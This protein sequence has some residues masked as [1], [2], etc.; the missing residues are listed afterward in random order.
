MKNIFFVFCFISFSN[1]LFGA[2]L[3]FSTFLGAWGTI[4]GYDIV[5]NDSGEVLVTGE[6]QASG[7]P[8]TSGTYTA[9]FSGK[10][11]FVSKFSKDGSN[12]LFSSSIGSQGNDFGYG[13]KL[14]K[15]EDIFIIGRTWSSSFP[16]VNFYDSSYNGYSDNFVCKLSSDGATIVY[17]SYIGG[18]WYDYAYDLAIDNNEN[19]FLLGSVESS[20]Y[21]KVNAFDNSFGGSVEMTLT[22]FDSVGNGII[23]STFIGGNS[24]EYGHC[25]TL[26]SFGNPILTGF[27]HSSDY[28]TI[29][30]SFD[31]SKSG[32]N[33]IIVSKFAADGQTLLFSTFIGGAG[34]DI[35][36]ALVTNLNDDVF[37]TGYSL[38]TNFPTANGFSQILNGS[39]DAIICKVS[40]DGSALLYSSFFGG[41][42]DE[43]GYG[44]SLGENS[45]VFISGNTI[46]NDLPVLN[47][48][49]STYSGGNDIFISH[50]NVLN[51]S[52]N[53]STYLG[54][55]LEDSQDIYGNP[56]TYNNG[57]V[58][59]IGYTNSNFPSTINSYDNSFGGDWDA[60]IGSLKP[61]Y[62]ISDLQIET[63][64]NNIKLTWGK[65]PIAVNYKI[66]RSTT[67]NIN[68]AVLLTTLSNSF[69]QPS[70]TD[71]GTSQNSDKYFYFVTWED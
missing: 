39:Q 37:L 51:N 64:G 3:D 53:F 50:L 67:S 46:S 28:P 36:N 16:T 21:P 25:L 32:S 70:F 58:S 68:N 48:I 2:S 59:F 34:N 45:Q 61:D 56:L 30:G 17:S 47:S 44:I 66:Y 63:F 7:F 60:V 65:I 1:S 8:I 57:N 33:D 49:D 43:F 14:G 69:N 62:R 23:F 9:G 35:G 40:N 19:L 18:N 11:I 24:S 31:I 41:S 71:D 27:A 5:S 54:S 15:Y 29:T 10:N 55:P 42:S 4:K 52:L 20:S 38:S 6:F 13:I 26:D 12:L 22:K